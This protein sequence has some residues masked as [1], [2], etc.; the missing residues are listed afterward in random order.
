MAL[1]DTHHEPRGNLLAS[2]FD[3]ILNGMAWLAEHDSRLRRAERLNA[4]SDE[5]LA[6]LG[7]KRQDIVR[8]VFGGA[9]FV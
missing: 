9:Y 2:F 8:H 4:M 6:K 7:L 3:R 1:A 5:Q